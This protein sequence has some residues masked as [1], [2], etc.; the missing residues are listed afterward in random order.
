MKEDI[1][2]LLS[3]GALL[4]AKHIAKEIG[5]TRKEVNSFLHQNLETYEKDSEFRW[6]LIDPLHSTLVLPTGWVTGDAF[7]TIFQG[8][9]DLLN[10]SCQI[11][12][13]VFSPK[14]K[15]MIDC[16]ARLLALMNQL[17]HRGKRVTADFTEAGTTL[18]YLNRA[19]FFDL[20]DRGVTVLPRRPSVSGAKRYQ[21]NSDN[22]VELDRVDPTGENNALIE[23]LTNKFVQQSTTGYRVAALT[24][25]GELIGNVFE[26]SESPLAGFA[27]LQKYRGHRNHIQTVV[28]DSGMGIARTLRPALKEHYPAL[29]KKFGAVS[30][31]SDIGLVE[32]AMSRGEISRFGDGRGLGFKSSREQ[33]VKFNAE[34]SV[35]QQEFCLKFE[36]RDGELINVQRRS[37]LSNLMGTH[38]CFDFFLD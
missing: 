29:H 15:T 34:F 2:R 8:A 5:V 20:L 3:C 6:H 33:A 24:V 36:Y 21:G 31:E 26:H 25:F 18:T 10:G 12:D 32:A 13:F 1:D 27:G 14:C 30:L 38:I 37:N 35:R 17:T 7:E 19:G 16:I 22:L 4:T 23:Q 9:G 11:I 28:S